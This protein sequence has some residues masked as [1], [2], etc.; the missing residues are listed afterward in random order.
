MD[1]NTATG[2]G[3]GDLATITLADGRVLTGVDSYNTKAYD[4]AGNH[5]RTDYN[6][7]ARGLSEM[8][9]YYDVDLATGQ[10]R[11]VYQNRDNDQ[12]DGVVLET[13]TGNEVTLDNG[14]RLTGIDSFT[15]YER[16]SNNNVITLREDLNG[17]GTADR[18]TYYV[19][20]AYGRELGS[21]QNLD[22]DTTKTL[23][24]ESQ[25]TGQTITLADG[26]EV[27]GIERYYTYTRDSNGNVVKTESNLDAKGVAESVTYAEYDQN[28]RK[29]MEYVNANNDLWNDGVTPNPTGYT[30]TINGETVNG[31]DKVTKFEYNAY[32]GVTTQSVNKTGEKDSSGESKYTDITTNTYNARNQK[33]TDNITYKTDEG[34]VLGTGNAYTYDIYGRNET[35][36]FETDRAKDGYERI[37][38]YTR[39]LYGNVIRTDNDVQGDGVEINSYTTVIRDEFGRSKEVETYV[40][41]DEGNTYI[42]T[43]K[44]VTEYDAYN[45]VIVSRSETS[46]TVS[47]ITITYTRN[48]RGYV[49]REFKDMDSDTEFNNKDNIFEY[50]RDD[51]NGILAR[52]DTYIKNGETLSVTSNWFYDYMGRRY[53][54]LSDT[55]D[56]QIVDAGEANTRFTF[57]GDSTLIDVEREYIGDILQK[58]RKYMYN[59]ANQRV[60]R[61]HLNSEDVIH[62]MD[63]LTISHIDDYTKWDAELLNQ[64][65]SKL[66]TIYLSSNK[67]G[68]DITLDSNVIA[69]FSSDSTPKVIAGDT[70]KVVFTINGD[71]ED[72]VKLKNYSEFTKVEG[73]VKVGSNNYDKLTT[74][75]EGKTYTLLVDTDIQLYDADN[76]TLIG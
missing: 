14:T 66:A 30:Y 21:Y 48:E 8:V 13:A 2:T 51:F 35:R 28:N 54:T 61:F 62:S 37:E 39:D 34:N 1:N 50:K 49:I 32:G 18:V 58:G 43:A 31:I 45:S 72:I 76:N 11:G 15:T 74:E 3:N 5:I 41:Y 26:R 16:D 6:Y 75:V 4:S 55:N 38:T 71:G 47:P 63:Y 60:A 42:R 12:K 9:E 20:D 67:V 10:R 53:L 57:V 44:D 64:I 33:E 7:D 70:A 27:V 17:D 24:G 40:T 19:R 29:V 25:I 56:N 65:G 22:N 59:D 73:T 68:I 46:S 69:K 23:T 36:S 52:T